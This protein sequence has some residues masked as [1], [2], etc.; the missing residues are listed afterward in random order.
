MRH[1]PWI[2]KIMTLAILLLL[3]ILIILLISNRI[4]ILIY[5]SFTLG[6][7]FPY[8]KFGVIVFCVTIGF[9]LLTFLLVLLVRWLKRLLK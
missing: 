2:M 4:Y 9:L 5:T 7:L 1:M 3:L 6:L 8:P